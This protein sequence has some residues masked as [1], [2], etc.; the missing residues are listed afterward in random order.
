MDKVTIKW[1]VDRC[2]QL[3]ERVEDLTLQLEA[4]SYEEYTSNTTAIDALR[5]YSMSE[6]ENNPTLAK[7][8]LDAVDEIESLKCIN[9]E[10]NKTIIELIGDINRLED[11]I[12]YGDW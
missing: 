1:W 10:L 7:T 12:K 3:E 11:R 8:C 6:S 5:F 9:K 2:N 4:K